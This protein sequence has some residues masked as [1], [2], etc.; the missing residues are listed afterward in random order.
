MKLQLGRHICEWILELECSEFDLN[1]FSTFIKS[2]GTLYLKERGKSCALVQKA[3][4]S[5]GLSRL[6]SSANRKR[7]M[8][9]NEASIIKDEA[10][11]SRP[12]TRFIND[13]VKSSDQFPDRCQC[14]PF[15]MLVL[16]PETGFNYEEEK[17]YLESSSTSFSLPSAGLEPWA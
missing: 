12:K 17:N 7:E 9:L 3:F 6:A 10:G 14:L 2:F 15:H 8:F 13:L 11:P 4:H 16:P 1:C 5:Q